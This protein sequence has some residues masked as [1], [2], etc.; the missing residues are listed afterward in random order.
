MFPKTKNIETSFRSLRLISLCAILG[1]VGSGI[2]FF[3]AAGRWVERSQSR[4]Y[5]L[6]AGKAF[7]TFQSDRDANLPAETRAVVRD[8]HELFFTLDP[9]ERYNSEGLK[10]ALYLAD[11]SAKRVYDNL[12]ESGF[13]AGIVS[14][15][16]SVRLTVDS[17]QVELGRYPFRFRLVG[18]ETL[19]R[20]T[21]IVT[22]L[23]VTEGD[24][25]EV[26]RSE[27]D[28]HGL[29]IERWVIVDNRDIKIESR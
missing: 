25:R 2:F 16:M 4:V 15:N 20:P 13:Y 6:A 28:P 9:D 19:T 27:N 7:E 10:Q 17:I 24:I 22:R 26:K 8:F 14:G 11:G 1:S 5:V 21:S 29:L 23:L 18:H 12:K 3:L